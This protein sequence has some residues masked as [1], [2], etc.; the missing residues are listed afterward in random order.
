MCRGCFVQGVRRIC[1]RGRAEGG[2]AFGRGGSGCAVQL[3]RHRVSRCCTSGRGRSEAAGA[4]QGL[5]TF[6]PC[7]CAS[8]LL[9]AVNRKTDNDSIAPASELTQRD[10]SWLGLTS[11]HDAGWDGRA[12]C[13]RTDRLLLHAAQAAKLAALLRTQ[14]FQRRWAEDLA[15]R[16]QRLE[17]LARQWCGAALVSSLFCHCLFNTSSVFAVS[18]CCIYSGLSQAHRLPAQPFSHS[19]I[20]ISCRLCRSAAHSCGDAGADDKEERDFQVQLFMY[21]AWTAAASGT[22]QRT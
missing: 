22:L 5:Q 10:S 2:R 11:I 16:S 20:D 21:V 6:S 15:G 13:C 1:D 8:L 9:C 18:L 7:H 3:C 12:C 17:E 19:A 14:A 4:C